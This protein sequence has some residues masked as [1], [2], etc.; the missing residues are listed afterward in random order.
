MKR[1]I[2][3]IT[4]IFL[5]LT[6]FTF[7]QNGQCKETIENVF[8]VGGNGLGNFS[9]IQSAIDNAYDGST[10][11]VYNGTY[12]ENVFVN[13]TVNLIGESK[14]N[15]IINGRINE[16]YDNFLIAFYILTDQVNISGFTVT[17]NILEYDLFDNSVFGV[18][19]LIKANNTTIQGNIIKENT[20]GISLDNSFNNKIIT[21]ILINNKIQINL[22]GSSE[23]TIVN[24][25]ITNFDLNTNTFL[26]LNENIGISLD[27]AYNNTIVNNTISN[28][29]GTG[30]QL[31]Y[32]CENNSIYYN[33]FIKNTE[34]ANDSGNNNW[35]N[36]Q[37]G[38]YWDDYNESDKNN[39]G[40][41]DI[42]YNIPNGNNKDKYPLIMPYDGTF[43]LKEFYIDL[44][45]VITMLIVG[46]IL[47][48]IFLIPIAYLW[49]KK[50]KN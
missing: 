19:I 43:R 12:Y 27:I 48:I 7:F 17:N 18:G 31:S 42:I 29:S 44:S 8:Y 1:I 37:H 45:S 6:I 11:F 36:G 47:V 4:A 9:S 33:N 24:T 10:I 30:I 35:D 14:E 23:N 2:V 50:T 41:G 28:I 20:F 16:V 3:F 40:I 38:N 39:D 13:K 32:L 25:T 22:L 15:T 46:M 5:F 26:Q 49:N 34:N 21:N